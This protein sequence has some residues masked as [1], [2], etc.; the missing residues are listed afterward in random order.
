MRHLAL[1]LIPLLT[2]CGREQ[3][4]V[5]IVPTIPADLRSPC[6]GWRGSAPR[7]E[8][9]LLRAIVAEVSGRKCA[10]TK[11]EGIDAIL[12]GAEDEAAS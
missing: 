3:N 12:K 8:G 1:C 7:T 6:D 11:I 10:N 9:E 5:V 4:T 2:G